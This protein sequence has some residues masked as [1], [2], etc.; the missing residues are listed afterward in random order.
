[1]TT[2]QIVIVVNILFLL[3]AGAAALGVWLRWRRT[4][5]RERVAAYRDT[6]EP[7]FADLWSDEMHRRLAGLFV[8]QRVATSRAS[9]RGLADVLISFVRRRLSGAVSGDSLEDV[10]L[11]LTILGADAVR[12]AQ[13]ESGQGIDLG[14]IDFHGA[15]LSGVDLSGFRLAHC[16]FD[17]SRLA[18]A[19]LVRAQ[20]VGASF[21]GTD[22]H[23][24]DLRFADLSEADLSR[25][26][27]TG[28]RLNGAK[29]TGAD[30]GGAILSEAEGLL[31]EQL[32]EAF[33]DSE[34]AVP[35]RM[36]FAPGR[37]NRLRGK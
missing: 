24:A 19:K 23:G 5:D 9:A 34:T 4:D 31:Q 20:L 2:L 1:M 33:G 25:A 28:A 18:G 35:E 8:A 7:L 21:A 27:F 32:D 13:A 30:I 3:G 37:A 29:I 15:T 12:K 22:L 17:G 10:R 11:A 26:D 16:R 14:G 36:R 6:Y